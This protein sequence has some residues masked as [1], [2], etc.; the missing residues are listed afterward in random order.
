LFAKLAIQL[1]AQLAVQAGIPVCRAPRPPGGK[2]FVGTII[3]LLVIA[4]CHAQRAKA[5]K[6]KHLAVGGTTGAKSQQRAGEKSERFH[7]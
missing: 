2:R 3:C 4:V 7:A 5:A 6:F 1:Q